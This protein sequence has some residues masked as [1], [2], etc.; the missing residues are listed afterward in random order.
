VSCLD[1]GRKLGWFASKKTCPSTAGGC[2][3]T[4]LCKGCLGYA[5]ATEES[6][7]KDKL[8]AKL[9]TCCKACFK[10]HT[11][12]DMSKSEDVLGPAPG[13]TVTILYVHGGGGCRLMFRRHAEDMVRRGLRCVLMDLPGHGARMDEPLTLELAIKQIVETAQK[14]APPCRA[15]GMKPVLIGGSL[16]GYIG[17][18]LLGRHPDLFSAAVVLMCGQNVGVGRGIAASLGLSAMETFVP[19]M[20]PASLLSGL[21][22]QVR[23]NGNM[24]YQREQ[25]YSCIVVV[26]TNAR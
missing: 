4:P 16:G 14:L 5:L 23:K 26:K 7:K 17:M 22:S 19:M 24:R 3:R 25:T 15:T 11:L 6:A 12:L 8:S 21:L 2:G 20:G 18:E 13:E 9:L 10:K 1:C